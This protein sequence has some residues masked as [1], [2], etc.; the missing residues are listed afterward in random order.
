MLPVETVSVSPSSVA[1]G[2]AHRV[3]ALPEKSTNASGS[4]GVKYA[5]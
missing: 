5:L 4:S 3:S 1:E 2:F